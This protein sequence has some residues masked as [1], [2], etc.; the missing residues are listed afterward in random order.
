MSVAAAMFAGMKSR[1]KPTASESLQVN[2][3]DKSTH[4]YMDGGLR[5]AVMQY[6]AG[7]PD[8]CLLL[9]ADK[10]G[11]SNKLSLG[12]VEALELAAALTRHANALQAAHPVAEAS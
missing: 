4:I 10:G 1:T 3:H 6:D 8:A 12:A 9:T 7:G 5:M 11:I 2:Q